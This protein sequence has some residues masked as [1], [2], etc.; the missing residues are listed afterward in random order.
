[1]ERTAFVLYLLVLVISPLLFGAVHT[2]AYTLV[3]MAVL[4][5]SLLLIKSGIVKKDGLYVLRWAKTGM[6]PLFIFFVI[7]TYELGSDFHV[8]LLVPSDRLGKR[9]ESMFFHTFPYH[10]GHCNVI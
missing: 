5:A 4:T 9:C 2:W 10:G 3:F 1:M 6:I 8:S 7:Y